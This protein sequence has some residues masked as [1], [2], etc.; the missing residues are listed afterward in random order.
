MLRVERDVI[1]ALL[2]D[3]DTGH[4]KRVEAWVGGSLDDMPE[5]LRLGVVAESVLVATVRRILPSRP[6]VD[7]LGMMERSPIGLLQQYPRL[8]RSLVL[9]GDLESSPTSR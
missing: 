7:L 1:H 5:L 4:A 2:G 8:F 3:A 6:L 9:F